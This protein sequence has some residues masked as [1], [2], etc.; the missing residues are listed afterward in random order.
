MPEQ[1]LEDSKRFENVS[2]FIKCKYILV[3]EHS[4]LRKNILLGIVNDFLLLTW[5]IFL[6]KEGFLKRSILTE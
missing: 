6:Q 3:N 2:K 5:K 1:A 4:L